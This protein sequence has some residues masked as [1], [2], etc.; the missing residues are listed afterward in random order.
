VREGKEGGGKDLVYGVEIAVCY[1]Q[2]AFSWNFV[3]TL[4]GESIECGG[5]TGGGVRTEI[6]IAYTIESAESVE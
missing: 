3:L 2:S 4:A 6:P 5:G 1:S